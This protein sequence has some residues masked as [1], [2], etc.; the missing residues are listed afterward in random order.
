[1]GLFS[2]KPLLPEQIGYYLVNQLPRHA[3][4]ALVYLR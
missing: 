2:K 4:G 1:M 3:L